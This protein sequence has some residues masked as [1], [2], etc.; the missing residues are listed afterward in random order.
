MYR[1]L[2]YQNGFYDLVFFYD[3]GSRSHNG[4]LDC[5]AFRIKEIFDYVALLIGQDI[6]INLKII[7]V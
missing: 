3:D 5:G 6:E 4:V 2:K 1:L 7:N